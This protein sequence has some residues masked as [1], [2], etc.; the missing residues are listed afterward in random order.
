MQ[1]T[2]LARSWAST[3]GTELSA[4]GVFITKVDLVNEANAKLAERD[5]RTVT[6]EIT[7]NIK[8]MMD[9]KI[10][11]VRRIMDAAEN[12]AMSSQN[13]IL[14]NFQYYNAKCLIM[15]DDPCT[16]DS[17]KADL[18]P[19]S[20][21]WDLEVN[22]SFSAVHVPTNV[23]DRATDVL[24]AIR[25]S[26]NLNDIF[27]NNYQID[28]SLTWQ[29][30]GSSTGFMRQFPAIQWKQD[31]VD[32][33][34]C[35]TRSW[36]IEAATSPKDIVILVDGSGSMTGIRKE[37]ARHVVNNILD[38]LGN[39]DF[40]NI[41]S[42]NETTTEVE[43]CFKDILVQ[44][45]LANIRNFKEKME[46][47]T[48]SNIANFSFAL[49]KAFHLLQKYR[50]NGSDDYSG[51]HCN[52]AIM[53]ITDGVP[54]NFKEIF[55]EFNW[56]N[57]PVRVFTYLVG[58][59][60][61]DVREIK[62]MACANRGY[63]VHLSTLAE[64]REQVLQY[65]PV[66][67]RPLVLNRTNHPIIWT[68]VYADVTDPKM[69]DW[70]WQEREFAEQKRIFLEYRKHK[71]KRR[72]EQDKKFITRFRKGNVE[73]EGMHPYKL[74]TSVSMP[75][76]DRKE[77]ATK[78]ANLLG[79]AGTDVPLAEMQKLMNPF[80][81]G[82][83]AY[84]FIVTNNGYILYHPDLR[85]VFQGIL[86]PN[87]NSIDMAEIELVSDGSGP[88]EFNKDL[89]DLRLAIINQKENG[90]AYLTVKYHYDDMKR[91]GQL[92]RKYYYSPIENS[93]FTVVVA[94]P[95]DY[96]NYRV[97]GEVELHR[98][99]QV[100]E[101]ILELFHGNNWRIHPDWIY[102]KYCND[103]YIQFDSPEEELFHFL[104]RSIHPGWKWKVKPKLSLDGHFLNSSS[105]KPER[106]DKDSYYCNYLL[107]LFTIFKLYNNLFLFLKSFCLV[108]TEEFKKKFGITVVFLATRSG[109]TRWKNFET[110][111]KKD[112]LPFG[113]I[114]NKAIDEIWYKRAVEQYYIN[115]SSFVYSVPFDVGFNNETM[116]TA[117]RAIFVQNKAPAAVVGYQFRH[118]AMS[119]L[120][121]N[122]VSSCPYADCTVSCASD[123]LDCFVLD[124]NGYVIV[125]ENSQHTGRFFGE[126]HGTV[127]NMLVEENIYR[128]ITLYDYQAVCFPDLNSDNS[129]NT[130][131]APL[132]LS[133][134]F[135][136]WL[137]AKLL[138]I[139]IELSSIYAD[140]LTS[141]SYLSDERDKDL[142]Q[143]QREIYNSSMD[144][145][146]EFRH[147][148]TVEM[149]YIIR[150]TRPES[151]DQQTQLYMLPQPNNN[152]N[153]SKGANGSQRPF[154][155][156]P[157]PNTNL[158][159]VIV[160]SL[161]LINDMT[162]S[163]EPEE[164]QYMLIGQDMD[165]NVSV[166]CHKILSNNLPRKR[167][168]DCINKHEKEGQIELCGLG[169]RLSENKYVIAI[170]IFA[171][172]AKLLRF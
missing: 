134:W 16:N 165:I 22:T 32:L 76:F 139:I 86:K 95:A 77:N 137:F 167:P 68:P 17:L 80:R 157:I 121:F 19:N 4:S 113:D 15:D 85:P 87:Y 127:M 163:N 159:L 10:S 39:N 46:D 13:E 154:V 3:F 107:K 40:V 120:F 98:A 42:F 54:Y 83:N 60:V 57:M 45:N 99:H 63:Y 160:N 102:C 70:L 89:L 124:N 161:C 61:A 12:T 93:P 25:W 66:M 55:A 33:Y 105:Q 148:K 26:E 101:A 142:Q 36:F 5:D 118:S 52:Q 73:K 145:F 96:G 47:I 71:K 129:G 28:P 147:E 65:I 34:D 88:R 106:L 136:K 151:C 158:I 9:E 14:E 29:Y 131:T 59:E 7:K 78:V 81:L 108:S 152:N 69:T 56:P 135:F 150:K 82:V 109:L 130:L 30:F 31:P 72:E 122:T 37:I 103:T 155:A 75:V 49:S 138:L 169:T 50:E 64:V 164:I 133:L 162:F 58:R 1:S 149:E 126:I 79:V 18:L 23:Y 51:A 156:Q 97:D 104:N 172:K 141:Y 53:L 2:V 153:Y 170:T 6:G 92:R 24:K 114:Y 38:T 112:H 111:D 116:V 168:K 166:N 74:M 110:S 27:K 41:L 117:S 21:F 43:P 8:N 123:D 171:L 125:S 100:G 128:R 44:A 94:I 144:E 115:N 20:H 146:S 91:V 143:C 90:S 62:W 140:Y 119:T 35:R 67:A 132:K 84:A 11:A 48:T